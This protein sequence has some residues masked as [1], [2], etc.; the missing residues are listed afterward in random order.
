MSKKDAKLEKAAQGPLQDVDA[1]SVMS[2]KDA[3]LEKAAMA[4][5]KM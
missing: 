5:F 4:L 3:K 1:V 2:K